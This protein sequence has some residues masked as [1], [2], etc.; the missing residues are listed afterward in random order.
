MFLSPSTGIAGSFGGGSIRTDDEVIAC[1]VE[2][3]AHCGARLARDAGGVG[4]V[5]A[6]G[7]YREVHK[8]K[9]EQNAAG[10]VS[11]AKPRCLN[12]EVLPD[13]SEYEPVGKKP[14]SKGEQDG[15]G[16]NRVAKLGALGGKRFNDNVGHDFGPGCF[17]E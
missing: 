13:Q 6:T 10:W 9:C 3:V 17:G 1:R 15:V 14:L 7:M 4:R 11:A 16:S 8:A 12:L 5:A 2:L